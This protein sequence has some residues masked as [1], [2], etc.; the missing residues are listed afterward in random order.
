MLK[1]CVATSS[2]SYKVVKISR[3]LQFIEMRI[4]GNTCQLHIS[5]I[6]TPIA[7]YVSLHTHTHTHTHTEQ[8]LHTLIPLPRF[9]STENLK[10]YQIPFL[11]RHILAADPWLTLLSLWRMW[12]MWWASCGTD[13]HAVK[14]SCGPHAFPVALPPG[15]TFPS[16]PFWTV[17]VRYV[18]N[19][20]LDLHATTQYV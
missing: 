20:S 14:V 1:R 15:R 12:F 9:T 4:K 2:L 17:T 3:K 16:E 18:H 10:V 8:N 13:V 5:C 7:F 19:C 6:K 11:V